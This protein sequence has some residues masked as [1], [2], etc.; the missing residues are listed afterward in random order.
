[1]VYCNVSCR[2]SREGLN[3]SDCHFCSDFSIVQRL[4][5][6]FSVL[7]ALS[8][9]LVFLTYILLPRLRHGGYSSR[10][11]IYRSARIA[12]YNA[13]SICVTRLKKR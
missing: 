2:G 8:C 7:S 1:M 12:Y 10:V 9:L 4:Y 6:A 11:F 5:L 13:R 3:L